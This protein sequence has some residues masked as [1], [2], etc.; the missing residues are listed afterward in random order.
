[1]SQT[2]PEPH[3]TRPVQTLTVVLCLLAAVSL[4]PLGLPLILA[5]WCADI[6]RPLIV[7]LE[8]K[9]GGR[10]AAAALVLTLVLLVSAM[11]SVALVIA[12]A[13][14]GQELL[15]NARAAITGERAFSSLFTAQTQH[16]LRDFPRDWPTL[17]SRYGANVWTAASSVARASA[18]AIIAVIVFFAG[19]YTFAAEGPAVGVWLTRNSPLPKRA[20]ERLTAAFYETGRGLIVAGGG[21]SVVQGLVATIAYVALSI[22]NALFLGLLTAVCSIVPMV[23]TAL[24]WI[25]LAIELLLRGQHSRAAILVVVGGL[26][27]VIDNIVRPVL[28]RFGNLTLPMLL[29]LVSMLGG[30]ALMGAAGAFLGPLV[31]RLAVESLQIIKEKSSNG[32]ED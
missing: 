11:A 26:I 9:L 13:S 28:A 18:S 20:M 22:P 24:V 29:V 10:K 2:P 6:A 30:I 17:M 32:T 14:G 19:L 15:A 7:W 25:P 27:G 16:T 4:A 8:P 5:A 23:G 21:T 3:A 31:V 1:M 12:L